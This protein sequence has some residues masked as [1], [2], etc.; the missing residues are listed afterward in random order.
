M[1]EQ[2]NREQKIVEIRSRQA[3]AAPDGP[4]W[5]GEYSSDVSF[6]LSE[7][8]RLQQEYADE[9]ASH[10]FHVTELCEA[11][12]EVKRLQRE[13]DKAIEEQKNLEVTQAIWLKW[14]NEWAEKAV[15]EL[16]R[17]A[18]RDPYATSN[19]AKRVLSEL[20]VSL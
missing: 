11:E 13:R 7:I 2:Y 19:S 4:F 14:H 10:N 20:G 6:L 9:R 1:T 15:A 5:A 17:F 18:E 3:Y 8:D 16:K 12:S